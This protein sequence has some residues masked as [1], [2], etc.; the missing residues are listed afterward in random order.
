MSIKPLQQRTEISLSAVILLITAVMLRADTFGDPNLHGDEAFYFTV[1][2]MMHQG[3]LPYVDVWDRKPLGLFIL[4][5]LIAGVSTAPLAYQLIATVFAATTAWVIASIAR[6]WTSA[7]GATLSGVAYLLVLGPLQG[8]GGQSPVFYNLFIALAALIVLRA[9]P[10]LR[11]GEASANMIVAMLLAG[12]AI[13]VKT[14]ALFEAAYLGIAATHALWRSG[15]KA[16]GLLVAT[17]LW[18]LVG[19]APTLAISAVYA[20]SGH[21]TEYWHAM[22]TSN[23]ARPP[24][25]PTAQLRL[26]SLAGLMA[27]VAVLAGLGLRKQASERGFVLGW[28]A[29]ALVGLCAVPNFYVH[30][31]LP[32]SV[33][34]FVAA[35]SFL[36]RQPTGVGVVTALAIVSCAMSSPLRFGHPDRSRAA[37]ERLTIAA[38][39]HSGTGPLFLYD[40]PPQLYQLTGQPFITPLV[41][42][43]HLAQGIEKDVSHLSTLGETRRVLGLRPGA[44]IMAVPPRNGPVNED[45]HRLVLAYVGRNCRLVEIV[46]TLEW[47]GTDMIAVWGDC[48]S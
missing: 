17:L 36:A 27:P 9:L 8:F 46:P 41:F 22:V 44:V 45:T 23:L 33:P 16:A 3:V 7:L 5:Y 21:W 26:A 31:A 42:P 40:A 2:T 19:A 28:C 14:T 39:A 11:R 37:I 12:V 47:L 48:R 15:T 4:Y 13:T 38:K 10:G 24:V 34:L 43:T 6:H 20:A 30:Y 1:G 35:S 32:L 25:W 29:A 18:M